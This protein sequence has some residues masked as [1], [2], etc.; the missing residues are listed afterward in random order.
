M[1]STG[2]A[3]ST[4]V[5][6]A[7]WIASRLSSWEG[8]G[9]ARLRR[10]GRLRN[11]ALYTRAEGRGGRAGSAGETTLGKDGNLRDEVTLYLT[12]AVLGLAG[13]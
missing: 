9:Q 4:D 1:D 10:P 6:Q 8:P 2:I 13:M 12:F 7:D 5:H 11:G 3:W